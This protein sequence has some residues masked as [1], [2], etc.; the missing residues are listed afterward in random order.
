MSDATHHNHPWTISRRQLLASTG[1]LTAAAGVGIGAGALQSAVA[2]PSPALH[3]STFSGLVGHTF[4]FAVRGAQPVPLTL[5][6]VDGIG[7]R[8]PT[9]LGFALRFS[10]PRAGKQGGEVGALTAPGL[11]FTLLVVPSGRP[12]KRGQDWVATIAGGSR[13]D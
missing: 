8:K 1:V 9:E 3:A 6:S 4:Q 5:E 2:Q 11:A 7:R 12:S 13:H 10:G